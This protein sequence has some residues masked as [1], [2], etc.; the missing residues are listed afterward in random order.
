M[1]FNPSTIVLGSFLIACQSGAD[2]FLLKDGTK[3]DATILREDASSY[4]LEV[5]VTKTIKDEKLVAKADIADIQRGTAVL[6]QFDSIAKFVPTPD[7]LTADEY[8]Q[9]IR[10]VEEFLKD[11]LSSS[12][13]IEA[14]HILA[15]LMAEAETIKAGGIKVNGKILPADEYRANAC[16]IDAGIR[17]AAI[18]AFVKDGNFLP[19]L[20]AFADFDRDF[21]NTKAR[22]A[23]LPLMTQ[24]VNARLEET[25]QLL[26]TLEARIKERES[27]LGR[28]S[29]ADRAVTEAAIREET[30]QLEERFKS[31]K[32][33]KSG[34]VT[35]HPDFKPSLDETMAFGK[36]ELT[37]LSASSTTPAVDAGAAYREAY[38]AVRRD[39]SSATAA[40]AKAKA[41][42]VPPKYLSMLEAAAGKATSS[43]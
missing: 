1:K 42:M 6:T 15:T 12:K 22:A 27:G 34:W 37:R 26:A 11:H 4:L 28:M 39:K 14:R 8:A 31:E 5:R 20:R 23:L 16:D 36:Q 13:S 9:R 17:E 3:L 33:A 43:P 40:I 35:T 19:A 24:V 30:A 29:Q 32:A 25:G 21:R 41:A 38:E 18:R 7:L 10:A 2:T